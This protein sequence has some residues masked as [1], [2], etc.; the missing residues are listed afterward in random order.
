M[1]ARVDSVT[2]CRRAELMQEV[3]RGGP[4]R[5]L[6]ALGPSLPVPA[7]AMVCHGANALPLGPRGFKLNVCPLHLRT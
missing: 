3:P 5:E 6:R 4:E 1:S 2:L 7:P